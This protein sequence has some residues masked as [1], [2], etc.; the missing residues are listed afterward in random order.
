LAAADLTTVSMNLGSSDAR[1]ARS[2]SSAVGV[3]TARDMVRGELVPVSFRDP[4]P[5]EHVIT[6]PIRGERLPDLARGDR[7]DIWATRE[8]APPA[9]VATRIPVVA[10]RAAGGSVQAL[11]LSLAEGTVPVVIAAAENALMSVVR[12]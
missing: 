7:V 5:L 2:I 11:S 9:L 8:G 6:V 4:A 10:V 1:Y 12:R 3:R